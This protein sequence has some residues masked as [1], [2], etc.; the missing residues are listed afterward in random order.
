MRDSQLTFWKKV[1]RKKGVDRI[2]FIHRTKTK[3][4]VAQIY[5][6][7]IIFGGTLS[8]FAFSFAKEMKKE[9][10]MSTLGKL[11]FFLKL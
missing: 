6:D 3:L 2:L 5:V 4:L 8:D 10:K 7:D 9:F 11:N 1:L